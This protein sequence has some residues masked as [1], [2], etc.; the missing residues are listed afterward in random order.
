[1]K[2]AYITPELDLTQV[3]AVTLLAGSPDQDH[4]SKSDGEGKTPDYG[5]KGGS[6]IDEDSNRGGMF[7][8]EDDDEGGTNIWD[9]FNN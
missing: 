8:D 6:D 7:D 5:G 3:E 9:S 1:M 4:E 2:K